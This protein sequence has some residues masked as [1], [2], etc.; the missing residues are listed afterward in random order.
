MDHLKEKAADERIAENRGIEVRHA[1]AIVDAAQDLWRAMEVVG[2]VDAHGGA[3][4]DRIFPDVIEAIHRLANPI[5]HGLE[6]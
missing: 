6:G 2:F 3:E 5:A 1:A 4:F